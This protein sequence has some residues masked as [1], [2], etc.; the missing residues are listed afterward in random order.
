MFNSIVVVVSNKLTKC[1][2]GLKEATEI[3]KS[4]DISFA[5]RCKLDGSFNKLQ[6][7][8][9][10]CWCVDKN[11]AEISATKSNDRLNCPEGILLTQLE[12]IFNSHVQ[13][14]SFSC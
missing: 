12:L 6:C 4:G 9:G 2:Q 10:E 8:N 14:V 5:P 13:L 1:E 7:W 3:M 11:G